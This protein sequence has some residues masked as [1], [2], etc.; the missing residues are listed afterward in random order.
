MNLD[1]LKY[2]LREKLLTY[3]KIAVVMPLFLALHE[4]LAPEVFSH[5]TQ[6]IVL[7]LNVNR[8]YPQA[9]EL[10]QHLEAKVGVV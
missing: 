9:I 1:L 8:K 6:L 4:V 10:V 2:L 5:Y 7:A 3:D